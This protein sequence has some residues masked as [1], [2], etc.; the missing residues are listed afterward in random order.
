MITILTGVIVVLICI[1]LMIRDVGTFFHMPV[2]HL[3]VFF[4]EMSL[5]H[6]CFLK[7]SLMMPIYHQGLG[8]C[9]RE[10]SLDLS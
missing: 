1:S 7:A 4:G 9:P 8:L 3:Y 5:W 2:D 10:T 6:Q